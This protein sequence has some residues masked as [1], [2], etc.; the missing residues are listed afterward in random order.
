MRQYQLSSHDARTHPF[1]V[2]ETYICERNVAQ[3]VLIRVYLLVSS[4]CMMCEKLHLCEY[5]HVVLSSISDVHGYRTYKQWFAGKPLMHL[6]FKVSVM[7]L[8]YI[9]TVMDLIEIHSECITQKQ[10]RPLHL[11]ES[12]HRFVF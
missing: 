9:Y 6:L 10:G 5:Q 3:T 7:E 1:G 11:H 12:N 8:T 4:M 2:I